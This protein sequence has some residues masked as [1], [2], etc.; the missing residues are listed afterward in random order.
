MTH[1]RKEFTLCLVGD[2]CGP[3]GCIQFHRAGLNEGSQN[4]F[5]LLQMH[6]AKPI[7]AKSG[8]QEHKDACCPKNWRLIE[9]PMQMKSERGCLFAPLIPFSS[10][11]HTKT[12]S[13]S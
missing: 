2:L 7:R 11:H 12:V 8:S 5:L 6:D 10:R 3:L 1:I 4:F 9:V 13:S